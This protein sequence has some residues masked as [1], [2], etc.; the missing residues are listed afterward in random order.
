MRCDATP[1][2]EVGNV[3]EDADEDGDGDDNGEGK[4]R[5]VR[6][7]GIISYHAMPWFVSRL[8]LLL[9]LGFSRI[10]AE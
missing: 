2:L 5:M 4:S 6:V 3:I 10:E 7:Y 1:G 8:S 9:A